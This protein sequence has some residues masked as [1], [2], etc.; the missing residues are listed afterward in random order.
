M[1]GQAVNESLATPSA[2]TVGAGAP[3][4]LARAWMWLGVLALIGSG[5]LAVLLVLSRTPGIQDVFPLKDLFRAALVVHVDLS[6]AVWFMAFAALVWSAIGGGGLTWL[7]WSG[8]ALAALGTALMSVSPFFPGAEP[9]LNNYIP[10]LQQPLF[11]ASLW[12]F[13]LGLALT[14]VRALITTWPLRWA[15]EPLR[16]GAFLAALAAFLALAAFCWSWALVPRIEETVYFEVLFWGGGH[17]LQFQHCLLMVVAWLWMAAHLG[18]PSPVSGRAL[19]VF[20]GLAALPLLAVP[21]IYL[22]VPAGSYEH[23]DLFARLM[24][25]GHPY[26]APLIVLAALLLWRVRKVP[27]APAKSAFVASFVLFA[28]GG[29]LGY[30]IQGVNVVI[31]AHYHGSTVGVTLAF[32]GL[33][34]VLL[35]QLGFARADGRLALWQ[36]YVYGAGQL[37]HVV[38]LAWSGGYG[39]QRKVAGAEQMLISLPQKIGMGMMGLGGLIAVIG[40]LMFVLVCLRAMSRRQRT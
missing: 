36:P 38:G 9:V 1:G 30:L 33:A 13:G 26:M 10:V 32:M 21:A 29:V 39:V 14:V 4:S 27:A 24:I 11:F 8:F 18:Q 40:G 31:P 2:V 20:F 16:L 6:V 15:G 7:A 25:W 5:L 35:P 12:L 37:I 17:T 3:I 22:L 28:L 19:S 23:M 34:Y